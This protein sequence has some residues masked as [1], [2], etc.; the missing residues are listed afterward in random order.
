MIHGT[1]T[2][3]GA[4]LNLYCIDINTDTTTGIGYALGNWDAGGVSP[5]VGYVARLLNDY[6]PH[7]DEPATLTDL[8]QR[9]AAV[10]AAIWFFSDR[11]VLS[12]SD[13]VHGAVVAIVNDVKSK[14]PLVEPPPPSLTIT[15]ATLSGPA[16]SAVGPF[17]VN[18]DTGQRRRRRPR[19]SGKPA[20]PRRAEACSPTRQA[21][22]RSPMEPRSTSGQRIWMRS[23]GVSSTAVLQARA[24]AI[25]PSGNV[26]LY[27]GNSGGQRRPA[28]HPG[29]ERDVDHHRPGHRPVPSPRLVGREEDDR[30]SR[31]RIARAGRHPRGVRPMAWTGPMSSIP[32]GAPAGV[33]STTY[34]DI[35]A[36]AICTVT[37]TSTGSVVGTKVT[38]T[39]DGQ[40]VTIPSGKSTTVD[41]TDTL[42]SSLYCRVR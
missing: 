29:R 12:T 21:T 26:Y 42:T 25:V 27:D 36:G 30:R 14:G 16:G 15:P 24:T 17:T 22:C 18:T 20:S 10:Q 7:T 4:T 35:P 8:N 6:Y 40:Q 13:A 31:R 34:R 28:A 33:T 1:P 32:A 9:A 3:G 39:G 19:A 37:E 38:V 23:T 2:D 41:V 5:R 11:Y